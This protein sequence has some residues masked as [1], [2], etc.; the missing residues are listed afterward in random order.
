M[1]CSVPWA[2]AAF[3]FQELCHIIYLWLSSSS[4]LLSHH[5]PPVISAG[6]WKAK[7]PWRTL[8]DTALL[9]PTLPCVS[10]RIKQLPSYFTKNPPCHATACAASRLWLQQQ[11]PPSWDLLPTELK[12]IKNKKGVFYTP[13]IKGLHLWEY[14]QHFGAMGQS[15]PLMA[16]EL[17]WKT[18]LATLLA[19]SWLFLAPPFQIAPDV[20]LLHLML[21]VFPQYSPQQT[22]LFS[23]G[24]QKCLC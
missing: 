6:R 1:P 10:A 4:H 5:C 7:K 11:P 14:A 20:S 24:F 17:L 9:L 21:T 3:I 18:E 13:A 16:A 19:P 23:S 22:D 2:C 8:G 15:S 12:K